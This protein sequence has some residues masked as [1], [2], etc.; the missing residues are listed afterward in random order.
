LPFGIPL[1]ESARF[2][3]AESSTMFYNLHFH[4]LHVMYLRI[5]HVYIYLLVYSVGK[6]TQFSYAVVDAL[7][8]ADIYKGQVR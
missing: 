2:F 4:S 8:T 7:S 3:L 6:T 5:P 1:L